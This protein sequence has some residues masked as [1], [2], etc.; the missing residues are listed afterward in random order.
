MIELSE[1]DMTLVRLVDGRRVVRLVHVPTGIAVEEELRRADSVVASRH[2]LLVELEKHMDG[3][4]AA[5][6]RRK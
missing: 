6:A 4:A 3:G 1:I 2:N 5:G